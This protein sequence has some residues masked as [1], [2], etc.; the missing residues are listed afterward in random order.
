MKN[1]TAFVTGI[2]GGLVASAIGFGYYKFNGG[3]LELIRWAIDDKLAWVWLIAG[4]AIG[5]MAVAKV[6]GPPSP[7][8]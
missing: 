2:L 4:I 7:N 8:A 6:G 3:N 1:P 5:Y